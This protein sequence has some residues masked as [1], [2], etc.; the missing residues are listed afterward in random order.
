ML[1][2]AYELTHA[3][4]TPLR[5][6]CHLGQQVLRNPFNPVA[7][8]LPGKAIAAACDVMESTTRRYGKPE[9]GL[10]D[11]RVAGQICPVAER[12]VLHKPFCDL[13][14]FQR[15]PSIA[16]RRR[17]PKVLIVA[18]MSGHFAT[19]LRGTVEAM[20]PEHEV[21]M[22]DWID[23]RTV[24]LMEGAFDL[25]DYIDYLIE[26]VQFLGPDVHV[27][28]V[29][30][31][32]PAVL[33]ATALMHQHAHDHVPATIT[34]M[35]G[36]IDPRQSPTVP[37]KLA[38]ERPLSWFENNVI[39]RVPWPHPG[40]MRR[41]YPGF[42]QLSGFM[43]MN[44]DRHIDAHMKMFQHLVENDGDSVEKHRT[45][46]DEYLSVMDL[47]AEFYLQ[48]IRDVFQEFKLPRGKFEHRGELVRPD[49]ITRTALMTVEGE[50]DDISGIGQTTAAHDI[51]VNI[52]ADRRIDYLQP[53]VGH[54]GVFNGARWRAEIQPRVRDFIRTHRTALPA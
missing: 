35:G 21:Y 53:K 15:E 20:L 52:P 10:D 30:Q 38:I 9:W 19:L 17:D 49:A 33:A 39:T 46:Y 45:F 54:Y 44:L 8:T 26:F 34:I 40:F 4:V 36:P 6:A 41:V 1:Y 12:V 50:N 51:C 23:A 2:H 13:L 42:L 31:P 3:A 28:G 18:P 48:T 11:T 37:N 47:T 22:T 43:S 29:C 7:Y 16:G 5:A 24:S 32:G 27:M 25:D 14:H